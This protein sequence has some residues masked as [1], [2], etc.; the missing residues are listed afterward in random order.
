MKSDEIR[1]R[2]VSPKLKIELVN[3]AKN[4]GTSLGALIKPYLR[5]IIDD[6]PSH[7]RQEPPKH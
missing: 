7:M 3:I 6:H 5:K 2:N 4:Q 1:L